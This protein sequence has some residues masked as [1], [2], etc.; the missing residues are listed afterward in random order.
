MSLLCEWCGGPIDPAFEYGEFGDC[1]TC[2]RRF[3]DTFIAGFGLQ[4]GVHFTRDARG[5]VDSWIGEETVVASAMWEHLHKQAQARGELDDSSPADM[6]DWTRRALE[7]VHGRLPAPF[8]HPDAWH[9]HLCPPCIEMAAKA[10][11]Q[12]RAPCLLCADRHATAAV[13]FAYL[14]PQVPTRWD[15]SGRTV[16]VCVCVHRQKALAF[17]RLCDHCKEHVKE[18]E[19]LL[20]KSRPLDFQEHG[21]ALLHTI[22]TVSLPFHCW[23]QGGHPGVFELTNRVG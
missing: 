3:N 23:M 2:W 20:V 15:A 9:Q 21:R 22:A 17:Y 1:E 16:A 19:T 18:D 11:K 12:L 8:A 6:V 4:D 5:M 10:A 14:C 13:T 7:I